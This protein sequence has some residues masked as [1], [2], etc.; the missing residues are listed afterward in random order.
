MSKLTEDDVRA[1]RA[2]SRTARLVAAD[3]GVSI[4]TIKD[5]RHKRTWAWL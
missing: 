3:Y 1:I 4:P 2:D 5:I